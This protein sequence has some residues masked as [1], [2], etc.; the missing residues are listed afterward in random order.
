MQSDGL[1]TP[2]GGW[3]R[4]S[5]SPHHPSPFH[6]RGAGSRHGS[7]GSGTRSARRHTHR[8]RRPAA[9]PSGSLRMAELSW[10]D[11]ALTVPDSPGSWEDLTEW[12]SWFD[13][14]V[15]NSPWGSDEPTEIETLLEKCVAEG[16]VSQE[17]LDSACEEFECFVRFAEREKM[18]NVRAEINEKKL[19]TELLQLEMETADIV[20]PYY[21]SKKYQLLQDVNRHLEAVLKGKKRL[22]QRLI[23]PVCE[24]TLPIK[25]DFHKCVMEL[26]TE[27]VTFIEK[28][29][30]HLQTVKMI[31]QVPTFMKNLDVALTKTEVM[32]TD[33]EELT[34]QILRWR[35]VQKEA[36]S[37]SVCNIAELDLGLST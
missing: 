14:T 19:E 34:E 33:L 36:Y 35:E 32:V 8:G 31:P 17:T 11:S 10:R 15:G 4:S 6:T 1:R 21:L 27:A 37:D 23:K 26:L 9:R 29:E 22:R 7:S 24:E 30:N 12:E 28:L 20:H 25:A 5:L 16:F 18:A 2:G 3:G 13:E